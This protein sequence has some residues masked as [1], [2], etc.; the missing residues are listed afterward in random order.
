MSLTVGRPLV[1]PPH[2]HGHAHDAGH[3]HAHD[4]GE[5][6]AGPAA[7]AEERPSQPSRGVAIDVGEGIGALVL[8][9]D[10]EREWMEPEI[11]PVGHAG[12]RQHVWV[13]ERLVSS[14]SVYAA[15]FP[16]LPEGRY[17]IC[18]PSGESAQEVE[19]TGGTVT[20]ARWL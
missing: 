7:P 6:H 16:S 9:A 20:E 8:Y 1:G 2:G 3:G 19:I 5:A 14:G 17:G 11:H 13:L 12:E 15:V 18:S 10:A 4:A